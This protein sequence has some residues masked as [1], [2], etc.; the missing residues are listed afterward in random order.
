MSEETRSRR[1]DRPSTVRAI[2]GGGVG[3]LAGASLFGLLLWMVTPEVLA[4]SIPGF[5]G[6][7]ES[8][9][10]GWAL[11]LIHGMV[12]GFI[13]GIIA[14][15]GTVF[16]MISGPVETDFLEGLSANTRFGLLGL[17]YG[18]AIWT[19]LPFIGL[20]L[21][22]AVADLGAPGFPGVASEMILGHILFGI[23]VGL[24]FSMFVP[25][26][27]PNTVESRRTTEGG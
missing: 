8:V 1:F 13:F 3:G 12:L 21:L 2:I 10:L 27:V 16:H 23:I 11:H 17:V 22:G 18:I 19:F 14:S 6:L 7:G 15:R 20:S 25:T 9:L 24:V 5:Y 26:S 4:E